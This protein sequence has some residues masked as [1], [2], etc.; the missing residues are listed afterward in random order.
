M[1]IGE[2]GSSIV[3]IIFVC[4]GFIAD[5]ISVCLSVCTLEQDGEHDFH[6]NVLPKFKKIIFKKIDL[7]YVKIMLIDNSWLN[8]V[9]IIYSI[10]VTWDIDVQTT[11]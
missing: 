4:T 10:H 3:E 6:V 8:Q 1:E 11:S 2:H 5:K 7:A 9:Q